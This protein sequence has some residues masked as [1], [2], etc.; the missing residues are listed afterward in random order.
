M[1]GENMELT[2]EE[3]LKVVGGFNI[4]ASLISGIVKGIDV[5]ADLGR[6]FG[7]TIR[8]IFGNKYCSL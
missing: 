2:K 6:T 4:T 7:T 1:R 8:R 5:I 3:L